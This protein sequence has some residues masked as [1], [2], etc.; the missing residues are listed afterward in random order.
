MLVNELGYISKGVWEFQWESVPF[1]NLEMDYSREEGIFVVL[2]LSSFLCPHLSQ[3]PRYTVYFQGLYP[4]NDFF[5]GPCCGLTLSAI[6]AIQVLPHALQ[7]LTVPVLFLLLSKSKRDK[8]A[9]WDI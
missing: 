8:L 9:S 6:Q 1:L 7:V 4:R 3:L 2:S 5:K